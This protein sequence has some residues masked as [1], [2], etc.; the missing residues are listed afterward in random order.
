MGQTRV[1]QVAFKMQEKY[2]IAAFLL[3]RPQ[4]LNLEQEEVNALKRMLAKQLNET[5]NALEDLCDVVHLCYLVDMD[6]EDGMKPQ[7]YS[8]PRVRKVME[9]QVK[10][11]VRSAIIS[12]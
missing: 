12:T 11:V 5:A 1:D 9:K 2:R 4:G 3:N 8:S 10:E 7:V 6:L